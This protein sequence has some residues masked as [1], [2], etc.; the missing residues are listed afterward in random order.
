MVSSPVLNGANFFDDGIESRGHKLVHW[1]WFKAFNKVRLVTVAVEQ[2]G[3]LLVAHST[4]DGRV[5]NFVTV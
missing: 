1:F 2:M 4:Q 3:E 5:G